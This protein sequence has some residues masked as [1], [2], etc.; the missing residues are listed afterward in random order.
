MTFGSPGEHVTMLI[1]KHSP[2]ISHCEVQMQLVWE[3]SHKFAFLR[4]TSSDSNIGGLGLHFREETIE[5][6]KI[7]I[8]KFLLHNTEY[9]AIER[10]K[11][12]DNS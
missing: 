6:R 12:W 7:F 5:I 11:A 1:L 10:Q 2:S 9:R 3:E 4:S 8:L